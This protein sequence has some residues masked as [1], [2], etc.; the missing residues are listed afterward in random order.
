MKD[1]ESAFPCNS[2]DGIE[3]YKGMTLRDYF[4]GQALSGLVA[5]EV[6]GDEIDA[7]GVAKRCY[8]VADAMLKER[9]KANEPRSK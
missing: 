5:D 1:G 2:P 3:S 8:L 6:L 4:A 9:E 7:T